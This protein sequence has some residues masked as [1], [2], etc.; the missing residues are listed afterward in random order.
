[1]FDMNVNLNNTQNISYNINVRP[2]N[3]LALNTNETTYND[4]FYGR[5]FGSGSVERQ[6]KQG[7]G[8]PQYCPTTSGNSE[9]IYAPAGRF[10]WV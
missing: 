4:L 8:Q 6:W 9:S 7:Q 3:L 10:R 1:M 2:E 5:V